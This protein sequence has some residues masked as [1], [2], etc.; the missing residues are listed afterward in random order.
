[1]VSTSQ[2]RYLWANKPE[3]AQKFED[4]TPKGKKLPKKKKNKKRKYLKK[5][6][7]Q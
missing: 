6:K 3:V 5:V 2:R 4:E 7:P 1:M